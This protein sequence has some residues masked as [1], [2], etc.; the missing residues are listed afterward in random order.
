MKIKRHSLTN[1]P[2]RYFR[3]SEDEVETL[4]KDTFD[5]LDS[6]EAAL[7]LPGYYGGVDF[8]HSLHCLNGLRKHLD[9]EYYEATMDV[10][11]EYRQMHIC[12]NSLPL[13][14]HLLK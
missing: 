9:I 6:M 4:K 5:T 13:T 10:P 2:D 7:G 1:S 11:P 14:N 8:L 12:K 3:F